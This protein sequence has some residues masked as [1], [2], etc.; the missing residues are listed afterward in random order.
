MD[1]LVRKVDYIEFGH[2]DYNYKDNAAYIMFVEYATDKIGREYVLEP[3]FDEKE[4]KMYV[5]TTTAW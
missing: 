5:S 3:L 1:V 2:I 4:G